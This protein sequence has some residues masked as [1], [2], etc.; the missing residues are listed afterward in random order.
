MVTSNISGSAGWNWV[1]VILVPNILRF[2]LNFLKNL[3]TPNLEYWQSLKISEE[4]VRPHFQNFFAL[5]EELI[6]KQ[7][8]VKKKRIHLSSGIFAICCVILSFF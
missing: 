6:T 1:H 5:Y 8:I 4:F 3:C 2:L 7:Q